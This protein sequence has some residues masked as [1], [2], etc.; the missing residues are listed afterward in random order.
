ML[1]YV[2]R[3]QRRV[4]TAPDNPSSPTPRQLPLTPPSTLVSWVGN[5]KLQDV[6]LLQ[7][8]IMR[9]SKMDC[10]DTGVRW[11][12]R[13][14]RLNL[15]SKCADGGGASW[16][17]SAG[18]AGR[19]PSSAHDGKETF[20]S[21]CAEEK[22][23][24]LHNS[25]VMHK[26]DST[27]GCKE[28]ACEKSTADDHADD[29][30]EF[31]QEPRASLRGSGAR[32]AGLLAEHARGAARSLMNV[33]DGGRATANH[34]GDAATRRR[35]ARVAGMGATALHLSQGEGWSSDIEDQVL[36]RVCLCS[37]RV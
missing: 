23:R 31:Q 29:A 24:V 37:M 15:P 32:G 9:C 22:E 3:T 21:E 25:N 26:A 14:H 6:L 19:S 33:E 11:V 2:R 12:Q 10:I 16:F 36:L 35:N 4:S 30:N 20:A 8:C 34:G 7:L 27:R 5:K 1:R 17:H 28:D 13:A 18:G